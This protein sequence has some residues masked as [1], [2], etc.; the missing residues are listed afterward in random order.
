MARFLHIQEILESKSSCIDTCSS[1]PQFRSTHRVPGEIRTHQEGVPSILVVGEAPGIDE[2]N[3]PFQGQLG[4]VTRVLLQKVGLDQY[5]SYTNLAKCRPFDIVDTKWGKK[6]VGRS[7]SEAEIQSCKSLLLDEITQCKPDFIIALGG[8]AHS[9]LMP[10]SGSIT[11]VRG[12]LMNYNGIKYMPIIHPAQL[13]RSGSQALANQILGDLKNV[14]SLM[15][16]GRIKPKTESVV[17]SYLETNAH[18]AMVIQKARDKKIAID[19]EATSLDAFVSH[20]SI[21]CIGIA[22]SPTEAYILP[23]DHKEASSLTQIDRVTAMR[24]I[25]KLFAVVS[26][27]T[28]H[29]AQYDAPYIR[30]QLLRNLVPDWSQFYH[31]IHDSMIQHYVVDPNGEHN[32]QSLSSACL[33]YPADYKDK[34]KEYLKSLPPSLRKYEN[35]PLSILGPYCAYD[36][37]ASYELEDIFYNQIQSTPYMR[38]FYNNLL[39]EAV[40]EFCIIESSGV[41]MSK[42]K[43]QQL[44]QEYETT[45]NDIHEKIVRNPMV[46]QYLVQKI[47]VLQ[48]R[49]IC[50]SKE[51]HLESIKDLLNIGS[52]R[53]LSD[54]FFSKGALGLSTIGVGRNKDTKDGTPVYSTD[55]ETLV[56]LDGRFRER[57]IELGAYEELHKDGQDP[58]R[59]F[60][61]ELVYQH[62]ACALGLTEGFDT[63]EERTATRELIGAY[64]PHLVQGWREKSKLYTSYVKPVE[65]KWITDQRW[66][67]YVEHKLFG[68]ITGRLSSGIHTIVNDD[69]IQSQFI[70]KWGSSGSIIAADYAAIE[71][72]VL[73]SLSGDAKLVKIF[74]DDVDIHRQVASFAFRKPIDQIS[75]MERR[76]AKTVHFG[77]L[78]LQGDDTLAAKLRAKDETFAECLERV[79][80]FKAGYFREFPLVRDHIDRMQRCLRDKGVAHALKEKQEEAERLVKPGMNKILITPYGRYIPCEPDTSNWEMQVRPVNY[81]IQST[82]TDT[83]LAAAIRINRRFR[84][85]GMKAHIL[86]VIHDALYVDAPNDEIQN[87]LKI[88]QEEMVENLPSWMKCPMKADFKVGPSWGEGK[89]IKDKGFAVKGSRISAKAG[90]RST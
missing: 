2:V 18:L 78:Y 51:P 38:D 45:L 52:P 42:T 88:M 79:K 35:I 6:K 43:N 86:F 9:A 83:T 64:V 85:S 81:P 34:P 27:I 30:E 40:R 44:I 29:N 61:D 4:M 73:A 49:S 89:S 80:E 62:W 36:T 12:Q 70:S 75:E 17:W 20:A 65:T 54:L 56:M 60:K 5:A 68:T 48:P 82:A 7:P 47:P 26:K 72:R 28:I 58:V 69:D 67:Y 76:Y 21:L 15:F 22:L 13:M 57:A 87:A 32:L 55:S 90:V 31:K 63:P 1:C 77:I 23:I 74:V 8:V 14:K 19:I 66:L 71:V 37:T 39:C 10:K 84:E 53:Q 41:Q 25:Y 59:I 50:G 11:K 24:F 16:E 33:N 3:K 46:L